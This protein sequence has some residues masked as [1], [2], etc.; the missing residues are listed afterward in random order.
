M[1][2]WLLNY[3]KDSGLTQQEVAD[4]AGMARTTYSS[5]EQGRRKPSVAKA[6]RIA[7]LLGFKWT[8]FFDEKLRDSSHCFEDKKVKT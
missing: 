6:M 4:K 3:R 8:L 2:E 7:S 1:N 5:I